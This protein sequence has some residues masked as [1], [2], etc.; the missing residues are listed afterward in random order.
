M[1]IGGN[2]VFLTILKWLPR[3]VVLGIMWRRF[4]KKM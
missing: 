3:S 1:C 4:S 2:S